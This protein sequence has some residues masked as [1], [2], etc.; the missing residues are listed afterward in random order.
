VQGSVLW[1][2]IQFEYE[3]SKE[4]CIEKG[5]CELK[6][7]HFLNWSCYTN[8][9]SFAELYKSTGKE[10][11]MM[12]PWRQQFSASTRFIKLLFGK[13]NDTLAMYKNTIPNIY[14][15]FNCSVGICL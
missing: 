2:Y 6:A 4:L 10:T 3:T 14:Y 5:E 8:L 1:S 12:I 13:G 11:M 9:L 15:D 7:F